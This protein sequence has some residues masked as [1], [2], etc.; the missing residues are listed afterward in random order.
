M[1]DSGSAL[2]MVDDRRAALSPLDDLRPIW[3]V[4]TGAWTTRERYEHALGRSSVAGVT[5]DDVGSCSPAPLDANPPENKPALLVNA[6]CVLPPDGLVSLALDHTLV[7]GDGRVVAAHASD[8]SRGLASILDGAPHGPSQTCEEASFVEHP[9]DVVR[10]RDKTIAHDLEAMLRD[11]SR[12]ASEHP[13]DVHLIGDRPLGI[14]LT[15][16]VSP[17]VVLDLQ[18]GPIV[19]LRGATVRPGA[20]L[21]GP[22]LIGEDTI[23]LEHGLIKA[24]TVI[25]PVCKVAGEI[26]GT[27]FQGHAN[28]A[29]HG[30][31]GDSWVGEWVNLGAGTVNSNLLNT[32]GEIVARTAPDAGRVRTGMVYLGAIIGDH[33]KTAIG[34]R[35][36]TGSLLATGTMVASSAPAPNCTSPFDWITD[37]ASRVYRIGKFLEVA[38]TMMGRRDV[39]MSEA[40]ESRLRALHERFRGGSS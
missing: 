22:C 37:S 28:K 10:F 27:I 1:H 13:D 33:V 31:L 39:E 38:A 35:I 24:N 2:V 9:W 4:R 17:G 21:V 29:H 20:T 16:S 6:R 25:G 36:M 14:D 40:Y 5:S 32:Y 26:G 11:R 34:T 23:V 8:P 3:D 7:D 19:I 30:H 18:Y 12:F 15:A